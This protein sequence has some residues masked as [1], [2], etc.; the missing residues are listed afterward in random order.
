MLWRLI[1]MQ[2]KSNHDRAHVVNPTTNNDI[3]CSEDQLTEGDNVRRHHW[4]ERPC[5][6]ADSIK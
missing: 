5:L 4:Q 1:H 6:P 3:S 2:R